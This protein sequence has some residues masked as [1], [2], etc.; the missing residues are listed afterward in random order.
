MDKDNG[1]GCRKRIEEESRLALD[2]ILQGAP[3]M[4]PRG[5][6]S[7][8]GRAVALTML[9]LTAVTSRFLDDRAR[10]FD[11]VCKS[12]C[13]RVFAA[14]GVALPPTIQQAP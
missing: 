5:A 2:E 13:G 7:R 1:V 10:F 11:T 8:K 12:M 14:A 3:D 6:F 4:P 9:L